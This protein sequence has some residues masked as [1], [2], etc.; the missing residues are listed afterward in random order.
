[1]EHSIHCKR[2]HK[3][4]LFLTFGLIALIVIPLIPL[5]GLDT[6][7]V[8]IFCGLL[9]GALAAANYFLPTPD[10][11]KGLVFALLP[12]GVVV[13]LF[14]LDHFSLNKHYLL[15]FTIIT[16]SLYFDKLLILIYGGIMSVSVIALYL[17]TP[18]NFLGPDYNLMLFITVYAII[19]GALAGM[20]FLTDAG[21]KLI[22]SSA[23]K[24]EEANKLVEQ[25]SN[26]LETI[27]Q[28]AIKLDQSTENVQLNM[29]RISEDSASILEAVEQM[30]NAINSEAQ[31][32]TEINDVVSS[33]LENMEQAAKVSQEVAAESQE[34]NQAME[35]NWYKVNQVTVHMGTLNDSIQTTTATVDDLQENLQKVNTLLLGI[36]DIANQ[37][38]LLALNA[39]I[40]AARAGEQG[41]GF[42]IVAEEVRKLAEQSSE[43][44]SRITEVTQQLFEKSKAAQE[45]SHEGKEAVEEG[46]SLLQEIAQTFT[47]MKEAF[48]MTNQELIGNMEIIRLTTEEFQ[49]I[50]EQIELAVS[51]TEEN[52]ATT[53]EIAST[54]S[55]E[56]EFI[57]M[58]SQSIMQ[59]KGL[60][61]ELLALCQ[62]VEIHKSSDVESN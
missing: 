14:F 41:R 5:Y 62:G 33:S 47:S 21:N 10:R 18:V 56:H 8:Y 42:A 49:K 15:F 6:A 53:E 35:E 2:V 24:E 12:L 54:I 17:G 26:L 57:E 29:G 51:V 39:A 28:S 31:N 61:E 32:I 19:L 55:S 43:I 1:M 7:K 9:V 59:L 36:E 27:D 44:A 16:V 23:R 40:E 3:I 46:Q 50:S 38:N 37:T 22:Q 4:N 60:S 13:A 11:V 34:M 25:L 45:K 30:A 58:I 52:T 20:G 48:A